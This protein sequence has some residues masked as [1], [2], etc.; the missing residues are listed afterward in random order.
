MKNFD[1]GT[2]ARFLVKDDAFYCQKGLQYEFFTGGNSKMTL[3][4]VY[5]PETAQDGRVSM[6]VHIRPA[7]GN[8]ERPQRSIGIPG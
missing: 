2:V 4:G 1:T 8:I 6:I 7:P 5:G 3:S